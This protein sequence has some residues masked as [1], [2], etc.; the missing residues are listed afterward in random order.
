MLYVLYGEVSSVF[1]YRRYSSPPTTS[2]TAS[3]SASVTSRD[4]YDDQSDKLRADDD[5]T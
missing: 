2:S 4:E 3:V 1:T 5:G